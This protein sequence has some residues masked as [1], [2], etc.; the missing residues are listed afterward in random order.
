SSPGMVNRPLPRRLFL[1]TPPS[2]S[3]TPLTC[4]RESP[5]SLEMV[6]RTSDLV[7]A[8]PFFAI[9]RYSS[10]I[11]RLRTRRGGPRGEESAR[12][13]AHARALASAFFFLGVAKVPFFSGFPLHGAGGA[14][15]GRERRR[16]RVHLQGA[17]NAAILVA[18]SALS[19]WST[20]ARTALQRIRTRTAWSATIADGGDGSSPATAGIGRRT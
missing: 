3:K 20:S 5:V 17:R 16:G 9:L 10:R 11:L 1:I 15:R 14:A 6:V 12:K 13:I 4:L 8:P 19:A 2:E 7:G 18:T